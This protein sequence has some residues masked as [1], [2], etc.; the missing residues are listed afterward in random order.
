MKLLLKTE[1]LTIRDF[2]EDDWKDIAERTAQEEVAL[3]MPW[4]T[5]TWAEREKIVN[6]IEEQRTLTFETV[7][8]YLEFAIVL[9]EKNIGD[10]AIKRLAEGHEV[11]EVGWVLSREHQ[12]RG[13]AAEATAALMDWCFR[14]LELHRMTSMC[15]A[16]NTASFKLMERL[17]MRREAH[18]VKSSLIKGEWVDDLIYAVLRDEWLARPKPTYEVQTH[19]LQTS[20]KELL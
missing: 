9:D 15:D 7:G 11:A 6:W 14:N 19:L 8:R 18:H 2:C 4:D 20:A 5:N 3:Y 1:R 17:G 12:G 16:K 10:V 13:Y